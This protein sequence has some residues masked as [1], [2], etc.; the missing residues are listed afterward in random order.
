[1]NPIYSPFFFQL[2]RVRQA[3][4]LPT[5]VCVWYLV[6]L[7]WEAELYGVQEVVFTLWFIVSLVTELVSQNTLMWIAGFLAQV[8]LA[9]V[10]VM[11]S[12]M[13]DV[14]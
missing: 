7:W 6:R 8:G 4:I 3:I 10:L 5:V 12:H 2:H 11:K 14:W 1:M 13:D 9:I